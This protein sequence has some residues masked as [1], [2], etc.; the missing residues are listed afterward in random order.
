MGK[1]QFDRQEA[2]QIAMNE[3]WRRGYGSCSVKALSEKL[4]VTRSSFYNAFGSREELF[5][6]ALSI[7]ADIRPDRHFKGEGW[8]GSI[9]D[10]VTKTVREICRTR[11]ADPEGKGCMAVNSVAELVGTDDVLGPDLARMVLS[12]L[13]Q[14]ER[15]ISL[16]AE[17]GE[18]SRDVDVRSKALAIQNLVIGLNVLAK[19]VRSEDDLWSA[20]RETLLGLGL[21]PGTAEA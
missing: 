7:Y 21:Y 20:A 3:I 19:V 17:N 18:L 9:L 16:A 6:E 14:F 11:A 15:L 1:L 8:D 13:G 4:G 2:V 5:W 12:G 10:L